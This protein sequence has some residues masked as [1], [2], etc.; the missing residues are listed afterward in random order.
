MLTETPSSDV[1]IDPPVGTAISVTGE[2]FVPSMV[3]QPPDVILGPKLA[4][5]T[6]AVTIGAVEGEST[7]KWNVSRGK[8]ATDAMIVAFPGALPSV[9]LV[10]A[11]PL[12]SVV[13]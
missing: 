5:S 11:C 6:T 2:R 10:R 1:N 8:P 3:A 4:P 12:A 9:T 13:T 7:V